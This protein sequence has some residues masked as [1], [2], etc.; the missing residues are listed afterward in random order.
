MQKK[1]ISFE[2]DEKELKKILDDKSTDDELKKM[3]EIELV[4]LKSQYE[5][6][7]KN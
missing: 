1:Y 5:A 7:E 4:D 3:A 2:S 6:N